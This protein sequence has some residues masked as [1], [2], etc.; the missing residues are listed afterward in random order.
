MARTRVG[1]IAGLWRYP[2]K[3][4]L[5]EALT[6][7]E[8]GEKGLAGDRAYA[9]VDARTGR[10]ISAKNPKRWPR[11]F[12]LRASFASPPK[13]DRDPPPVQVQFP[14]G[15]S[16]TSGEPGAE[17]RISRFLG[18][19]VRIVTSTPER[20]AVEV[21]TPPIPASSRSSP[22]STSRRARSTTRP[23]STS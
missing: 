1:T 10:V 5:G 9:L 8:V 23:R 18:G 15:D 16:V 12:E 13:P 6:E 17:E 22:S 21:Y 11:M 7:A 3:S 19:D 2:V 4:M 20:P 14:D